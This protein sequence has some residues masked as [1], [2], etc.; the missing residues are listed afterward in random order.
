MSRKAFDAKGR[1]TISETE[2]ETQYAL[3]A[4]K[5]PPEDLPLKVSTFPG[6]NRKPIDGQ[7]DLTDSVYRPESL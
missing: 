1:H 6:P 4:R 5:G 3:T 7:L 2:R